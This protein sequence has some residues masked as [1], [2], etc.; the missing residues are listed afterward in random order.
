MAQIKITASSPFFT[1]EHIA[2]TDEEANAVAE[3]IKMRHDRDFQKIE[4]ELTP[5]SFGP[6]LYPKN[7]PDDIIARLIAPKIDK[8]RD[9]FKKKMAR[10]I[11]GSPL[12]MIPP[13]AIILQV[14]FN[15]I[16]TNAV[17]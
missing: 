13:E 8:A 9:K 10:V 12:G 16:P 5:P 17:Q 3:Y 4:N 11:S 7:S 2:E 14:T 1:L 15:K 6:T